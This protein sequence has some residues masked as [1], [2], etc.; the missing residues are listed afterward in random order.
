[1]TPK[2]RRQ[3]PGLIETSTAAI[4]RTTAQPSKTIREKGPD[5]LMDP[6][7]L[8]PDAGRQP[9]AGIEAIASAVTKRIQL[10]FPK[11]S[12]PGKLR[13]ELVKLFRLHVCTKTI[14]VGRPRNPRITHACKLYL[15]FRTTSPPGGL[16]HKI[17][18]L[19]VSDYPTYAE[20]RQAVTRRRLE[21]G[22]NSRLRRES[23]RS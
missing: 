3:A 18:K 1:M 5:P 13:N 6:N 16:W 7:A 23:G 17:A 15:A 10:R 2:T 22:V 4:G 20:W 12:R 8:D 21:R 19:V 11:V 14:K 9:M